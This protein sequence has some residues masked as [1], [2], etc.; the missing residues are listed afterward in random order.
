MRMIC[1][2][3]GKPL[4]PRDEERLSEAV[5]TIMLDYPPEL[6]RNGITRMLEFISETAQYGDYVSG[7]RVIDA[8]V[9]R[10]DSRRRN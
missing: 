5:D 6:R 3:D 4:D 9:A 2:R 8:G 10:V 7:P 1:T